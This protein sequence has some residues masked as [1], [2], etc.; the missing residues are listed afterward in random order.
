MKKYNK[1]REVMEKKRTN[2]ICIVGF[3]LS[4]V[5]SLAGL[6]LSIIGL[7]QAKRVEEGGSGL[8][9][10]GIVI[11]ALKM[12]FL[13]IFILLFPIIIYFING[14]VEE[15]DYYINDDLDNK[16]SYAYDCKYYDDDYSVCKY[17]NEYDITEKILCEK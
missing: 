1:G 6:V 7:I 11:S 8:A 14:V 3:V 13:V 4:F 5:S 12:V 17:D 10:A 2:S 15:I 9:I 16:C